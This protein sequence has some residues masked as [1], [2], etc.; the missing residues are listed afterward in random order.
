LTLPVL[1]NRDTS[2][3]LVMNPDHRATLLA[4]GVAPDRVAVFPGSGVDIDRF[5]PLP[6]P[7]PP[8]TVAY[9]GRMLEDKGVRTLVA[10]HEKLRRKGETIDLLLAGTP[11]P[12]NPNSIPAKDLE[13][14]SQMPGLRWIGHVD[15]VRN[16][17]RAAHI[18]V[19]ASR[20]EGLPLSLLEAA[21]CGRAIVA[22]DV[23]GC[24]EIARAGVNALLVP[25]DNPVALAEA[26]ERLAGDTGLRQ[27]FATA[28]RKLVEAQYS[29]RRVGQDI[30]AIYHRITGAS[31]ES[32]RRG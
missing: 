14:W 22:T 12:A 5:S 27:R 17:W 13:V 20:A 1:L 23:P 8:V 25:P 15:D 9:A 31:A 18:A 30:V 16:V 10:A 29:S 6:E 32:L 21:A 4:S 24:R 3:T 26:I 2:L 19:L 11:D 28:G 7:E